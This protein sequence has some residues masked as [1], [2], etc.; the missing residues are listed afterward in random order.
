[1]LKLGDLVPDVSVWVSPGEEAR[2]LRDVLGAGLSLC[3]FI[4]FD[5]S[6]T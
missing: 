6:P 3:L 1:M 4:P 2:P 5:W